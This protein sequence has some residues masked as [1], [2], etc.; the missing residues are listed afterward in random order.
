MVCERLRSTVQSQLA[1]ELNF[2]VTLSMGI[3]LYPDDAEL[4]V[5]LLQQADAALYLAKSR[6]R[7]E[8]VLFSESREIKSMREKANLRSLFSQA[9]ADGR[10]EA[11]YQ[12]I[13]DCA[14]GRIVGV[15]ALARWYEDALGWVPPATFIP[16]AEEMGLISRLGRRVLELAA[17]QMSIWKKHG[18]LMSLSVNVSI[19]Q[20]FKDDFFKELSDLLAKAGLRP[21]DLILEVTES[22]ALLGLSTEVERL[23]ELSQSGFRLSIDDFGAGYSSLS[24]LHDLPVHELKIDMKF[25]HNLQTPK[26]RRIVQTIVELAHSLGL[27]TVAEG[28]EDEA[29]ADILKTMG[30]TRL[31]GFRYGR[32]MSATEFSAFLKR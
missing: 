20:I 18:L 21:T 22:Q 31:Q 26:G 17:R 5:E 1:S 27:Q 12:P 15:E 30:V 32:P 3:A 16:L 14:T 23:K 2:P 7:D 29:Q 28:V 6:G 24:T 25:V 13:V 19:R 8:V 10:M 11:H 9:V 4:G